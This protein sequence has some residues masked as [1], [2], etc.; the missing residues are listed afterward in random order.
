MPAFPPLNAL[1]VFDTTGKLQS[2]SAAA[3]EL[4]ITPAAVSRQ[5]RVLED[6]LGV[7]L[8]HREHR[9]IVLT[10][11]GAQYH[12]DI[13][14]VFADLRRATDSIAWHQDSKTFNI[15]APHTIAL[16]W[17]L[18]K[19]AGLHMTHPTIEVKL[20]TTVTPPDFERDDLDAGIMLGDGSW[21]GVE[22][23][24]LMANEISPVCTPEK[25]RQLMQ[26]ADLKHETLLHTFARPDDWQIWLQAA[27]ASEVDTSRGMRYQSSALAYEAA[28]E[29][30]GVAIAQRTMVERELKEGRLVA[31]FDLW[32]DLG[33]QTYYFLLPPEGYKR[34]SPELDS[35]RNWIRSLGTG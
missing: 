17:L 4:C 16:R 21:K 22:V 23:W 6:Y 19:L 31:P 13:A 34:H 14:R 33:D 2:V 24:K 26:P 30:Y 28:V 1:R 7:R 29:G 9:R 20:H 11:A 8:F 18:P 3:V 27:Q 25:A 15:R 32:V 12:A 5:I 35:F 10:P